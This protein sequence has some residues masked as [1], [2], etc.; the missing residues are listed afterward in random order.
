MGWIVSALYHFKTELTVSTLCFPG[1][2]FPVVKWRLSPS[3]VPLRI[4]SPLCPRPGDLSSHLPVTR[5]GELLVEMAGLLDGGSEVQG[6]MMP[7]LSR[8]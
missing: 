7:G 8:P 3:G 6:R 1:N 2:R 5:S 4:I